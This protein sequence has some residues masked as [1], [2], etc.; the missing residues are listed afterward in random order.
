M[1]CQKAETLAAHF[2]RRRPFPRR[3]SDTPP[4]H[5]PREAPAIQHRIDGGFFVSSGSYKWINQM[6]GLAQDRI[7]WDPILN[8]ARVRSSGFISHVKPEVLQRV[9]GQRRASMQR[10]CTRALRE[11][12]VWFAGLLPV[13]AAR[14]AQETRTFRRFLPHDA[15]RHTR[16]TGHTKYGAAPIGAAPLDHNEVKIAY[17]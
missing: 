15:A 7:Q 14:P 13:Q 6:P 3:R 1:Y 16:S 9:S 5:K 12:V 17:V 2:S 11:A 10:Q 4:L 8:P